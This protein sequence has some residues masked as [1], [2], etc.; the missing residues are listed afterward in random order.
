MLTARPH[1]TLKRM[2]QFLQKNEGIVMNY[3]AALG[4]NF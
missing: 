1:L 4:E 2:L 3:Q